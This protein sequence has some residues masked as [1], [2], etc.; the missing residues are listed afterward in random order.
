MKIHFFGGAQVVTGVCYMLECSNKKI[1]I[2][3]GL[4]QGE[5]EMEKKNL[6]PFVFDPK[7]IDAVIVSHSHLDHVGRLPQL[8]RDGFEGK[9][10]ATPPTVG[11]TQ[12][13]LED[14]FHILEEKARKA[15]VMQV[16]GTEEIAH[17][18]THFVMVDY[19]Q[20]TEIMPGI[21]LIFHDAGHIMGSAT[22]ELETEGKKIIFSGDLGNPPAPL[23]RPPDFLQQADYV[24]VESTYGDKN[25][26]PPASCK[27]LIEDTIEDALHRGG[28]LMIPSFAMERTQQLLYHL[29]ELIESN[30]VPRVPVFI[31]SPLAIRITEAYKRYPQYYNREAVG[32]IDSG[33]DIFNFPG[34][35]FTPTQ[36]ESKAINDVPSP[37]IIIAGSGMSQGGRILHHEVRYLSDPKSTLLLVSYQAEGT[38]GRRIAEGAK[39]VEILDQEIQVNARIE[40]ISGY[41]AH[42]DQRFLMNWLKHFKKASYTEDKNG[43]LKKVFVVQGE[44]KPAETLAGLIKDELGINVHVPTMGEV[45]EL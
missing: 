19:Y 18:M 3:C 10:F 6:E 9:I 39:K 31:D 43:G 12:L 33:D 30:C 42:A 7:E 36:K 22:I 34:L 5:K 16:F 32:E 2:D 1:L 26:E 11:F 15:G 29:N 44:I 35:K 41:S 28:V 17:V 25:H 23:V 27:E 37:K 40:K 24:L 14:S 20:K 21:W 4:F 8:I 45:I 38:L 13:I